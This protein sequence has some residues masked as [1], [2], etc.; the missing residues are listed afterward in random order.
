MLK[1]NQR[2]RSRRSVQAVLRKGATRKT[3]HL[4]VKTNASNSPRLAVV[5]SKKIDKRAVVR[6]TIRRRVF[7]A[8]RPIFE[9]EDTNNEVV[10]IV[11][12]SRVKDMP[13]AE[14]KKEI[15]QGLKAG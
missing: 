10:I 7:E 13:F 12:S 11:K 6:N 8:V 9:T 15:H 14:L 4:V 3:E 5:V 2:F 1:R